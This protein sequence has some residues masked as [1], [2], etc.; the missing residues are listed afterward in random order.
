MRR[1]P[2]E[3]TRLFDALADHGSFRLVG[4]A[5]VV[6]HCEP[7]ALRALNIELRVELLG[8]LLGRVNVEVR[9]LGTVPTSHWDVVLLAAVE[10][11]PETFKAL[12]HVAEAGDRFLLRFLFLLRRLGVVPLRCGRVPGIVVAAGR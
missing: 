3:S 12:L 5:H 8:G 10:L 11:V 7:P 9:G 1:K 4:A 2:T 6:G